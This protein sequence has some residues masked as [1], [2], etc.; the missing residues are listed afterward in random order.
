LVVGQAEPSRWLLA[1]V[2]PSFQSDN[3]TALIAIDPH[4]ADERVLLERLQRGLQ[5][6]LRRRQRWAGAADD[7]DNDDNDDHSTIVEVLGPPTRLRPP[8]ALRLTP[9]ERDALRGGG[10]GGNG[11]DG[12]SSPSSVASALHLWGWA[13]ASDDD[14]ST[15][16]TSSLHLLAVPT[17][18]GTPLTAWDFLGHLSALMA[19]G[20]GGDASAAAASSAASVVVPP[21]AQRALRSKACRSAL[22]FGD[23]LEPQQARG[24]VEALASSRLWTACAHGRPTAAALMVVVGGG[25]GAGAGVLPLPRAPL[26]L[27]PPHEVLEALEEQRRKRQRMGG[28]GEEEEAGQ[29]ER[30]GLAERLRAHL[31][32]C[33]EK[34]RK[35]AASGGAGAP[36]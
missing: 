23:A 34:R 10:G 11:N 31:A 16:S 9:Q 21:G 22:M 17:V 8:Q 12:S 3:R 29:Q 33:E 18:C 20:G 25:G 32:R 15:R 4:A 36:A 28:G 26:L 5:G 7:G 13:W 6:Q 27:P 1:V 19:G 2:P 30:G 24:L 35:R 14:T